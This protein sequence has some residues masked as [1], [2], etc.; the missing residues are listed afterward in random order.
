[1]KETFKLQ[2]ALPDNRPQHLRERDYSVLELPITTESAVPFQHQQ[3]RK[4]TANVY[5]QYST[6]SCVPHA[7]YTQLE[8]EGLLPKNFE[9]SQ[10]RA[11]RKRGNYPQAGSIATDMYDQIRS[12][13]SDDYVTPRNATEA[14]ANSLAYVL[15]SKLI[16]DFNYYQYYDARTGTWLLD[17]IPA[18]VAGGRA[19]ALY[20]YATEAEWREEFVEIKT[21]NLN[22]N[23]AYVRHA[24]VLVPEGD[25]TRDGKGWFSVHDSAAFGGRHLRHVSWEFLQRRIYFAAQVRKREEIVP[26]P[27]ETKLPTVAVKLGDRSENVRNLQVFLNKDGKLASNHIT[28]YYG[29]LTAKAVLWWQL[30]NWQGFADTIPQ[31]LDL[32]GEWWGRQSISIIKK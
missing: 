13:Q 27:V 25:F 24:V 32:K 15:G 7:F 12:G 16:E 19:I 6:G 11:Y 21:P 22:P 5:N 26:I 29:P 18:D 9:P 8:Y 3:I 20:I 2:D 23:Q 28:S 30:E 14:L 10:L 1:M 17:R 4:L 31:L